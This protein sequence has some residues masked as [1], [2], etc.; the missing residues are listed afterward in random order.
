[1]S[2]FSHDQK[3]RIYRE[4]VRIRR[5]EQRALLNY[6][7]GK[8]GGWLILGIGQESIPAVARSLMSDLD[9]SVCGHRCLGHALAAGISMDTA[10][11]ELFGKSTGCA[12]GKGG[13]FGFFAPQLRFHGGYSVAGAQTPIANGIALALKH[14]EVNGA[15][16]C[17]LGDGALNQGAVHE[18]FN[19]AS[20]FGLP[21]VFVLENNLYSMGTSVARSSRYTECLAKRAEAYDMKWSL[22]ED[23]SDVPTLGN[24]LEQAIQLAKAKCR[25][26]LVEVQTYRFYGF[27]VADAMARKYRTHEEI[28]HH[29]KFRDPLKTWH[30]ALLSKGV[31]T[32]DDAQAIDEAAKQ[33]AARA[34]QFAKASSA[35][36]P[37]DLLRHVYW[38]A[39]HGRTSTGTLFFE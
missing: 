11:A 9:H 32:A 36:E 10:M 29:K 8:V 18:S 22:V 16:L 14:Q 27:T 13:M 34:T 7:H 15:C 19:L 3:L 2:S 28:E 25:P 5:F 23:A 6:Q 17:F 37:S 12:Q 39:D 35:P 33:E 26:V 20:L 21:V 38:E 30:Q 1:M 31:L 4:M 24:T